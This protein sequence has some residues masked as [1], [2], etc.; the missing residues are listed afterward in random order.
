MVE[1]TGRVDSS[2]HPLVWATAPPPC[3]LGS[4]HMVLLSMWLGYWLASQTPNASRQGGAPSV[5]IGLAIQAAWN[6]CLCV[7]W[8]LIWWLGLGWATPCLYTVLINSVHIFIYVFVSVY[9]LQ[10]GEHILTWSTFCCLQLQNSVA[11]T[12]KS[13]PHHS[14]LCKTWDFFGFYGFLYSHTPLTTPHLVFKGLA[15]NCT[16]SWGFTTCCPNC[17]D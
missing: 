9:L 16:S 1:D 7:P 12:T 13:Q 8:S 10:V 5:C 2:R 17:W 11:H 3:H 6:H 4:Q 15:A 14:E